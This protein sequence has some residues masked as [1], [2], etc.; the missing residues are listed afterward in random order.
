MSIGRTLTRKL[1]ME[2][3]ADADVTRISQRWSSRRVVVWRNGLM[4]PVD[5]SRLEEKSNYEQNDI[6]VGWY[7][8]EK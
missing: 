3:A 2:L 7:C 1:R 4:W 8:L 5:G 6:L